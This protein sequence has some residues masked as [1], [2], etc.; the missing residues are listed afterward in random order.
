VRAILAGVI[1]S[2]L[3]SGC[4]QL[5]EVPGHT[6]PPYPTPQLSAPRAPVP[7]A[8]P[9]DVARVELIAGMPPQTCE[10]LGLV[11]ADARPG[12]GDAALNELRARAAAM[13]ADAV[14]HVRLHVEDA[15]GEESVSGD[16]EW[17]DFIDDAAG[18]WESEVHVTGEAVRYRDVALGRRYAVLARIGVTDRV[19]HE[20]EALERL[21]SR[22]RAMH[23]DLVIDIEVT[24]HGDDVPFEVHGTAIRFLE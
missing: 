13:G 14:V 11:E 23:A 3:A 17:A 21:A 20:H 12:D 18:T 19:G 15:P 10:V 9:D 8:H 2:S 1:A 24:N 7:Y 4:Y 16:P 6:Y 22:A 5:A